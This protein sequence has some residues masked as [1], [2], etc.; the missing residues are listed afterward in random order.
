MRKEKYGQE[1]D[2]SRDSASSLFA[3]AI[4]RAAPSPRGHP[5]P[6][7]FPRRCTAHDNGAIPCLSPYL[8]KSQISIVLIIGVVLLLGAIALF[9]ALSGTAKDKLASDLGKGG[10]PAGE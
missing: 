10:T 7:R 5:L 3:V 2:Y 8:K 1:S 4:R 9:T 6:P